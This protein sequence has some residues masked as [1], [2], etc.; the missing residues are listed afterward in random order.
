MKRA[1]LYGRA[2]VRV[3]LEVAFTLFG[4]LGDA[5]PDLVEWRRLAVAGLAEDYF[6]R[7]ALVDRVANDVLRRRPEAIRE[8]LARWRELLPT[9]P[10]PTPVR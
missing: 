2:P 1:R 10:G 8:D 7:R 6:R 5:P 3:D 4:W 9:G